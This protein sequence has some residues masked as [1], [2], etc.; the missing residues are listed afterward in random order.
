MESAS[1][2]ASKLERLMLSPEMEV[3]RGPLL[4]ALCLAALVHLWGRQRYSGLVPKDPKS[5]REAVSR[6]TAAVAVSYSAMGLFRY[7][8]EVSWIA[9]A[10]AILTLCW[11][12]FQQSDR[13]FLRW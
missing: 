3:L 13:G 4:F 6:S 11:S 7:V 2:M 5:W 10:F 8:P 12:S 1:E 9:L